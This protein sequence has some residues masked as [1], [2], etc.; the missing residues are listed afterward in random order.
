VVDQTDDV[1]TKNRT[2]SPPLRGVLGG[3]LGLTWSFVKRRPVGLG[4]VFGGGWG[5]S[6]GTLVAYLFLVNLLIEPVQRLVESIDQAQSAAAG[7]RKILGV[8]DTEIAIAEPANPQTLPASG[9][10]LSFHSVTFNYPGGNR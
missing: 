2:E 8:M 6:A 5:M 10:G 7:L 3:G 1:D 4:V 9:I